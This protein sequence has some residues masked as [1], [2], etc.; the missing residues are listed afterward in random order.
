MS[1]HILI[2][3]DDNLMRRALA[4]HLQ[5]AG[6]R[7]SNAASAETALSI[8][9]RDPPDLV[10]LDISLPGM[11]GLGA[12]TRFREQFGAPVIFVTARR[13]HLDEILGLELG[14]D[15]YV[16]K[17]FDM[18]VLLARVK[19]AL[20]VHGESPSRVAPEAL[21]YGDLRI[22]P[23][24]RQVTVGGAPLSLAPREYD[25]LY[26]LALARGNVVRREDLLT[27][28]WGAEFQGQPQALYVHISWLRE[29]LE[30]DPQ[31]PKR[32]ITVHGVGYKLCRVDGDV[33]NAS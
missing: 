4:F 20:R 19:V 2:V 33:A 17:P 11:G 16:T 6:F 18:D 12:L 5:Q 10:L 27:Q 26:A 13:R 21:Q 23:G 7:T 24:T 9:Q 30:D 14:A 31:T 32:I 15:D 28:V 25:L 1:Q 8:A 3:D 29:K 22:D